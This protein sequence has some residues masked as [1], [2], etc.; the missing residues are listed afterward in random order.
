MAAKGFGD[1]TGFVRAG[2]NAVFMFFVLCLGQLFQVSRPPPA[3]QVHEPW[4]RYLSGA[5]LAEL[6]AREKR[7]FDLVAEAELGVPP[8]GLG[9]AERQLKDLRKELRGKS[10]RRMFED[11]KGSANDPV[12]L[13]TFVRKF[14]VNQS[15]DALPIDVLVQ[16]FSAVFNRSTDPVPVVFCDNFEEIRDELLDPLFTLTELDRA[17][18]ALHHGMAPGASGIGNDVILDLYRV[19]GGPTFFLHLFNACFSGGTLPLAWRCTEIF[20]LYKGKGSLTDPNSYRGIALMESTLKVFERLL[21]GRLSIWARQKE[22]IPE[23][24]FGFRA[25]A[26]TLDAIFVLF[27]VITKYV[28][29]KG[30]RLFV[31]TNQLSEGLSVG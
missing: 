29:A 6:T 24:Q 16:H 17:F 31:A 10:Q 30:S 18:S 8:L 28:V 7:V 25:R 13:W 11:I 14:R 1:F 26:G 27:T 3:D 23:C 20:L 22:L 5:E 4:H 12:R 21:Y 15:Q 2:V 19:E 9:E